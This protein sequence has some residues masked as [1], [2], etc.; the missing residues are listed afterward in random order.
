MGTFRFRCPAAMVVVQMTSAWKH[1]QF[2]SGAWVGTRVFHKRKSGKPWWKSWPS[3]N[4]RQEKTWDLQCSF[5]TTFF[6]F[7][8]IVNFSQ[9]QPMPSSCPA[10]WPLAGFSSEAQNPPLLGISRSTVETWIP[11]RI[12]G[13]GKY[14]NMTGVY[15][16]DPWHTISSTMDP[17]W[18]QC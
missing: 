2:S 13:A 15:W 10:I 5:Y 11:R 4:S 7:W 12:H 14:A 18:V 6:W 17:S 1:R 9:W 8:S 3:L 16:W